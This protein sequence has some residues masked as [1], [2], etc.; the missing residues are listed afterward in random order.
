M[1]DEVPP[2]PAAPAFAEPEELAE[3][4]ATFAAAPG[5]RAA[6][7]AF[8]FAGTAT[9]PAS[10]SRVPACTTSPACSTPSACLSADFLAIPSALRRF[11]RFRRF[12]PGRADF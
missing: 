3:V 6:P 12:L 7:G 5:L 8:A 1:P 9:A 4:P 11:R 2:E 10:R